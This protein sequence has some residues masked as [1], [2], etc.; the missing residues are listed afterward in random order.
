M[1]D[2]NPLIANLDGGSGEGVARTRVLEGDPAAAKNAAVSM[3]AKDPSNN[4]SLLNT[5]A[6][7]NL[8]VTSSGAGICKGGLLTKTPGNTS[9]T[10]IGADFALVA[11]KALADLEFF[12]SCFRSTIFEIIIVDDPAGTPAETTI[13]EAVLTEGSNKVEGKHSCLDDIDTTGMTDPVLRV[14][15]QNLN[16]ASDFRGRTTIKEET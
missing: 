11:G 9:R 7:G 8:Q 16:V 5:D 6:N 12:L 14:M 3:V 13:I 15:G 4:L 2:I 10:Q 1:P